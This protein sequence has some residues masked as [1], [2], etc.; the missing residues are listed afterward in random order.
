M[1]SC[2]PGVW[3]LSP[4][5]VVCSGD[6]C[7]VLA[8][9]FSQTW[10]SVLPSLPFSYLALA[11]SQNFS[12]DKECVL[13][14]LNIG[15]QLRLAKPTQL[16]QNSSPKGS[17]SRSPSK[18]LI[19]YNE[20]CFTSSYTS[21]WK[22]LACLQSES[23]IIGALQQEQI[24]TLNFLFWDI[25][26]VTMSGQQSSGKPPGRACMRTSRQFASLWSA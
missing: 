14:I 7:V 12:N 9:S 5:Y 20:V 25:T 19:D 15:F 4:I 8:P 11:S 22:V 2:L 26:S 16:L 3:V 21:L 6:Q 13:C 17:A 24:Q 10:L 18:Y 1:S 23:V